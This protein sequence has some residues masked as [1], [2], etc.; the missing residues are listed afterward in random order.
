VHED[1]VWRGRPE[2]EKGSGDDAGIVRQFEA[3]SEAV[4][5]LTLRDVAMA[6]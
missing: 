2:R 6:R 5:M 3:M 1:W 4:L